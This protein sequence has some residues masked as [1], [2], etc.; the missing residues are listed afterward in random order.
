MVLFPNAGGHSPLHRQSRPLSQRQS[1]LRTRPQAD[2][3]RRRRTGAEGGIGRLKRRCGLDGCRLKG[4]DGQQIW[5]KWAV[6]SH[7]ADTL[8]V[9]TR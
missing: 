7:N 3:L 1:A 8:A 6:M 4:D 9:R 2:R 5:T